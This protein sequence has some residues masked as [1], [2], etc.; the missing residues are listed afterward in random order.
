MPQNTP[1]LIHCPECGAEAKKLPPGPGTEYADLYECD[2]EG[3]TYRDPIPVAKATRVETGVVR[4]GTDWP[5]VFIRGDSAMY[6]AIWL[7]HV[8]DAAKTS[9]NPE[10]AV[11]VQI[12]EGLRNLLRSSQVVPGMELQQLAAIEKQPLLEEAALILEQEGWQLSRLARETSSRRL[13]D[14]SKREQTW[15]EKVKQYR[16]DHPGEWEEPPD[17]S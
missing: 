11:G 17:N 4:F 12:L 14:F 5:G 7:G 16:K 13:S 3:C 2:E 1:T 8:L 9:D 15:A 6:Y 10:A